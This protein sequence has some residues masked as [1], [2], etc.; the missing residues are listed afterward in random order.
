MDSVDAERSMS[1]DVSF[2]S[3]FVT[4]L[5]ALEAVAYGLTGRRALAEELAQEAMLAVYRNWDDVARLDQPAAFARRVVINKSVSVYRRL[6]SEARAIGRLGLRRQS[7][8]EIETTDEWLWAEVRRLPIDQQQAI[9][10]R[11]V[12]D[13]PTCEIASTLGCAES[14]VRV[15]LHR[16]RKSLATALDLD[17]EEA[18]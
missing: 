1:A 5:P 6:A 11:Y 7:V 9:V 8:P 3:F 14:T 16:A 18:S 12:T 15:L 4:H 10:L 13:L 2:D 17:E